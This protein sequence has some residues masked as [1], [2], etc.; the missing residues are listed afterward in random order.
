MA[1]LEGLP[2]DVTEIG[3]ISISLFI[4]EDGV[5]F[6]YGYEGVAREAAIGYLT[7]VL[8]RVRDEVA[9]DWGEEDDHPCLGPECPSCGFSI[10]VDEEDNPPEA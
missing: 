4:G 1:A 7:V 3:N 5:S 8:D 9:L 2:E 6:A 10:D